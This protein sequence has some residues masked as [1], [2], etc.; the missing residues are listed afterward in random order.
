MGDAAASPAVTQVK[1]V[2]MAGPFS[3][4][5]DACESA[6]PCGFTDIDPK[7]GAEIKPPKLAS[8]PAL[9]PESSGHTDPNANDP[10]PNG[11][12]VE[13]RHTSG[14]LALQIVS[15]HCAEPDGS[16]GESDVYYMFVKRADGWW[17]S[18]PLWEWSY[19]DKYNAGSMT[20][21]WNDQPGG[22]FV[23]VGAGLHDLACDSNADAVTTEELM[24]R[25]EAGSARPLVWGPLVVGQRHEV[26][27]YDKSD[28][29]CKA[30]KTA[31]EL[32]EHWTSPDELELTGSAK[33][34]SLEKR[35]G[36][37]QIGWHFH[38]PQPS[39]AGSYKFIRP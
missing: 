37:L 5:D 21:R 29:K 4:M 36:I 26:T 34:A 32:T 39:S 18:D 30:S 22:T 33:W 14:A 9:E 19:N 31:Q 27:P 24:V 16:R 6:K 35:D 20:V 28:P 10:R 15:Q 2:G 17:R 8:C 13:L 3:T 11:P 23:G 12:K 25:V 1:P 7:T 38:D